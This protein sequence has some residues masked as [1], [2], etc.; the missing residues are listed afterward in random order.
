MENDEFHSSRLIPKPP[1][2]LAPPK[3]PIE[4]V[5]LSC[6]VCYQE[7]TNAND[8]NI[9]YI[10][11]HE[12][13]TWTF[14]SSKQITCHECGVVVSRDKFKKH[15]HAVHPMSFLCHICGKDF[16]DRKKFERHRRTVHMPRGLMN[17]R[18]KKFSCDLCGLKVD[19]LYRMRKHMLVHDA[20]R[21]KRLS[22]E[23]C[24]FRCDYPYSIIRHL[25]TH[26]VVKSIND[27]NAGK[28]RKKEE[29]SGKFYP[30]S[31][32]ICDKK[33]ML[34]SKLEIHLKTQA[35]QDKIMGGMKIA[36]NVN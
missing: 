21:V 36:E 23:F 27:Y 25:R 18:E 3:N 33:Y 30:F 5:D 16:D 32:E 9:H 6:K 34:P 35:H 28:D 19:Q 4:P 20:S 14:M 24:P 7:F 13:K 8:L 31:C 1:R 15:R 10:L 17:K 22:C 11:D 2:V 26:G 12:S 29:E